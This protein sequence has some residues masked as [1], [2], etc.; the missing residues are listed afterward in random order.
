[1]SKVI[2]ISE[3]LQCRL[4]IDQVEKV[5]DEED[6]EEIEHCKASIKKVGDKVVFILEPFDP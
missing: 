5:K 6:L 4:P 2:K 3:N 1:M